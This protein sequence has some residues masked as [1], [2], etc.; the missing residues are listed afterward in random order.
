[1]LFGSIFAFYLG[2]LVGRPFVN[3][4][5]GGSCKVDSWINRLK[6]REKILLFYMFLLPMFPDDL[7]CSVAGIL[8]ISARSFFAM[9]LIT[10]ATSVFFT[11]VFMSGEVS[12][13]AYLFSAVGAVLTLPIF[14]YCYKNADR[15]NC[16]F[17][18]IGRRISGKKQKR[19]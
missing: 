10:R 12:G 9:Q 14:I 6:G 19:E 7:L 11:I 18:S 1:M 16:F 8:P 2:R 5:A 3:W 17:S 15:V 4:L 13:M